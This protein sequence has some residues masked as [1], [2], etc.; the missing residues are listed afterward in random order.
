MIVTVLQTAGSSSYPRL[1]GTPGAMSANNIDVVWFNVMCMY[2]S[3]YWGS[4]CP[5]STNTIWATKAGSDSISTRQ[6]IAWI[7]AEG[8]SGL[9]VKWGSHVSCIC[10]D[11]ACWRNESCT[12]NGYKENSLHV[13]QSIGYIIYV[14][15]PSYL[16]K[17]VV[18]HQTIHWS[19]VLLHMF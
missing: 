15:W 13:N 18:H 3:A 11:S 10:N 1:V 5:F 16:Y 8:R 12:C 17:Q 7:T 4:S 19:L 2:T 6:P 14:A 9:V